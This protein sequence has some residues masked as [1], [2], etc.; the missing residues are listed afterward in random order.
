MKRTI[1]L[2]VV[3]V[4]AVVFSF[5]S[6]IAVAAKAPAKAPADPQVQ[7]TSSVAPGGASLLASLPNTAPVFDPINSL[8]MN[9]MGSNAFVTIGATDREWQLMNLSVAGS[10]VVNYQI[11]RNNPGRLEAIVEI[12]PSTSFISFVTYTVTDGMGGMSQA[13]VPVVNVPSTFSNRPIVFG[14][15]SHERVKVGEVK[16]IN[17]LI[18][19]DDAEGLRLIP[20]IPS[21]PAMWG[22]QQTQNKPGYVSG[23][24]FYF[25]DASQGGTRDIMLF[26][27]DTGANRMNSAIA[28]LRITVDPANSNSAPTLDPV[29]TQRLMS[30]SGPVT[31]NIG[32]TDLEGDQMMLLVNGPAVSG[33]TV[34][35]SVPGRISGTVTLN[36]PNSYNTDLSYSVL[37]SQGNLT[38]VRLPIYLDPMSGPIN[39]P[40]M[41]TGI[42]HQTAPH[43]QLLTLPFMAFDFDPDTL[44][45]DANLP[46]G[47]QLTINNSG[48]G[49]IMGQIDWIP[50]Q[51][52]VGD[53]DFPLHVKDINGKNYTI[54]T[55][56]VKVQ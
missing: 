28:T 23:Q 31:V 27:D 25:P 7:I 53:H 32:A 12:A 30:M 38:T 35:S 1:F 4:F 36:A 10:S 15:I 34:N 50:G 33:F 26:A 20:N 43:S 13:S 56:K 3:A 47:A 24:I 2:S 46:W 40:T 5:Q 9:Q 51:F 14:P 21:N 18:R 22:Y 54:G 29:S 16:Q 55:F 39:L 48:P 19:D 17:I 45:L 11:V 52:Q 37:D 44:E 6:S 42:T 49:F 41:L 8:T